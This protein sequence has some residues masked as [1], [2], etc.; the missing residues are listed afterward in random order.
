M[1]NAILLP[2]LFLFLDFW[3]TQCLRYLLKALDNYHATLDFKAGG[4]TSSETHRIYNIAQSTLHVELK[5]WYVWVS[6]SSLSDKMLSEESNYNNKFNSYIILLSIR[7]IISKYYSF[8][9]ESPERCYKTFLWIA[10]NLY[11]CVLSKTKFN[12]ISAAFA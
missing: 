12:N 1:F 2:F 11:A 6:Q 5:G 8:Y 3:L 10:V 4:L 9:G 7:I